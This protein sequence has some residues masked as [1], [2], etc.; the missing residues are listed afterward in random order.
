MRGVVLAGGAGS[1]LRPITF[2][3]AQQSPGLDDR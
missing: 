2:T 3:M 1:R